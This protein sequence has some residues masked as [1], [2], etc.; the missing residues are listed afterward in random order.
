MDFSV[1]TTS[2]TVESRAWLRGEVGTEPGEN[3]SVIVDL[4]TFVAG[5]HFPNGVLP[6]GTAVG[7]ITAQTSGERIVVG[8]YDPAATD[9]RQTFAGLLFNSETVRTGQQKSSNALFRRGNVNPDALPFA[10]GTGSVDAAA[11]TAR[12][13]IDFL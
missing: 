2:Y 12:P 4:T 13:Q 6:S 1:H 10:S 9:G 8:V 11:K 7:I 3:P 5:T